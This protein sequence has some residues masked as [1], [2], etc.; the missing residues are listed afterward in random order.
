VLGV[1]LFLLGGGATAYSTWAIYESS[2]PRDVAF[3][4]LAPVAV[5]ISL[6]GLLLI[7]VPGFFG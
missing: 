6:L 1:L 3:A 7:F 4:V 2:R 5:V